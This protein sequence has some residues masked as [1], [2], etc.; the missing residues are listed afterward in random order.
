MLE[1]AQAGCP[2]VLSGIDTFRELWTGAALF[3]SE[4]TADAYVAAIARVR[5]DPGLREHLSEAAR[6]RAARYTPQA[7]AGAMLA[8]YRSLL[9]ERRAAA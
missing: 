4:D 8:L 9:G 2:L 6:A 5:A 7:T 1:A 3:V